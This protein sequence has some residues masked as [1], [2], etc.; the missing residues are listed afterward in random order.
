MRTRGLSEDVAFVL[1][2]KLEKCLLL[3]VRSM[4]KGVGVKAG[5]LTGLGT[6]TQIFHFNL[7]MSR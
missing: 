4:G 5:V 6:L 2:P 3:V 7:K 1:R